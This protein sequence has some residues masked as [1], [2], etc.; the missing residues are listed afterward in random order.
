[1]TKAWHCHYGLITNMALC[2]VEAMGTLADVLP[3]AGAAIQTDRRAKSLEVHMFG[4][5]QRSKSKVVSAPM[6]SLT[7][8]AR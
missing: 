6:D 8:L 2:A 7:G 1:M 3:H 5:S 4:G